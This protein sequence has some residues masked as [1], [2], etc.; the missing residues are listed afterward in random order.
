MEK[1]PSDQERGSEDERRDIVASVE[2]GSGG[3]NEEFPAT[4]PLYVRVRAPIAR[5]LGT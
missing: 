5:N 2:A 3:R 1:Q 4:G